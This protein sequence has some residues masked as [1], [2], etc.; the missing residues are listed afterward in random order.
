MFIQLSKSKKMITL[1][2]ESTEL[3]TLGDVMMQFLKTHTELLKTKQ[4][5]PIF[6]R[7]RFDTSTPQVVPLGSMCFDITALTVASTINPNIKP[8]LEASLGEV[9]REKAQDPSLWEQEALL[10]IDFNVESLKAFMDNMIHNIKTAHTV[11]QTEMLERALSFLTLNQQNSNGNDNNNDTEKKEIKKTPPKKDFKPQY[12][13]VCAQS[14]TSSA[15][16][17]SKKP[18]PK[19]VEKIG[20][21]LTDALGEKF[22][23]KNPRF[24]WEVLYDQNY[25]PLAA[26]FTIPFTEKNKTWFFKRFPDCTFTPIDGTNN[27]KATITIPIPEHVLAD[28]VKASASL[29]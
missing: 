12:A 27:T 26:E 13:S 17:S 24:L 18:D 20:N 21:Y 9:D 29:D 5:T 8:I 25:N 10:K 7:P 4:P 14:D 28:K 22:M 2:V 16:Y 23:N 11:E 19:A 15:A 1:V 6:I 3:N